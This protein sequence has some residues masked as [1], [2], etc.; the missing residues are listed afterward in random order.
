LEEVIILDFQ[1]NFKFPDKGNSQQIKKLSPIQNIHFHNW[2]KL[3]EAIS[4]ARESL[5][6][7]KLP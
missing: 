6:F 2:L 7:M 1:L 4:K 3:K 5:F